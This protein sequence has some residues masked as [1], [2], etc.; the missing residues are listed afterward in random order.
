MALH[1]KL[2]VTVLIPFV[3]VCVANAQGT[4]PSA[5][6]D[7]CDGDHTPA[8]DGGIDVGA[9]V[10]IIAGGGGGVV[11]V[12]TNKHLYGVYGE[13]NQPDSTWGGTISGG[14][15]Q[16]CTPWRYYYPFFYYDSTTQSFVVGNQWS[17]YWP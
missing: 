2:F 10:N 1:R 17:A 12:T 16:D 11:P 8:K 3:L 9:D 6:C 13:E 7:W 5:T 15:G 14:P 4:G